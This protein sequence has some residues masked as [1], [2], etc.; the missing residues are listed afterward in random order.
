M[1]GKWKSQK[2]RVERVVAFK[3]IS[4]SSPPF[5]QRRERESER[6]KERGRDEEDREF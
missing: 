6:K 5:Y 3:S 4:R 2:R 1:R